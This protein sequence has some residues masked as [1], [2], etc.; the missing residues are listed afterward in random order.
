MLFRSGGQARELIDF[1]MQLIKQDKLIYILGNHEELLVQCLQQIS[2]GEVYG[3]AK[4]MSHHYTN[5]TWDTLL[6]IA[7]MHPADACAA[8]DDLLKRVIRSEFYRIL[9]PAAVDYYETDNYVFVHGW[10]PCYT[11]FGKDGMTYEYDP[12]WRNA[13]IDEWKQARWFNGMEL[14]CRHS[15]INDSCSEYGADADFSPF[16]AD[17][18]IAIDACAAASGKINC[19]VVED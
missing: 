3:I 7:Q 8:P 1:M 12:D 15:V 9:L 18:I 14:A 11:G 6:Q 5:G 17:G 2:R 10:I 19:V 13:Y 16:Y 4:G